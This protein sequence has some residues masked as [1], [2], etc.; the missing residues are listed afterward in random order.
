MTG[1]VF[2]WIG[3]FTDQ[4]A[5]WAANWWFLILVVV[6]PFL[7]SMIPIV[8]G[9]TT[10]ILAGVAVATGEAEY[11]LWMVIACGATGAFLGDNFSYSIG[12]HYAGAIEARAFRKPSFESKLNWS[13]QQ[14][15]TRG[16]PLLITARFI[17]GGRTVLTL[18]C[19]LTRQP[20]GWFARWVAIAG[21]IW[22]TFAAG[23]AYVVGQPFKDNHRLAFWVAFGTALAIN[24]I[25]EGIRHL[26]NRG[27]QD[28]EPG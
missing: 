17:P 11:T 19:G 10:V 15:T 8:P 14:I 9:E 26:R 21:V 12:R 24:L 7:D 13:H 5:D 3:E 20:H 22:A 23:L 16:G 4:L 25:I 28:A 6:I 1:G 18:A 27:E 2:S